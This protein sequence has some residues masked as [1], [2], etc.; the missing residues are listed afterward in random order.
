MIHIII[1]NYNGWE[2]SIECI[3]SILK[4]TFKKF[5]ITIVDN[6]S[7]NCSSERLLDY[8]ESISSFVKMQHIVFNE[9]SFKVHFDSNQKSDD[10]IK[11]NKIL[12]IES[13]QNLGFAAGNNAAIDYIFRNDAELPVSN[14]LFFLLNP[15][16]VI[17]PQILSIISEI[18]LDEFI[19]SMEVRNYYNPS[20]LLSSG[21]LKLN[22]P[23]SCLK[24]TKTLDEIDY[25]YGGALITTTKT[26]KKI[27]LFSTE[28]F[29]Y[30]EETDYC[31]KAK[32]ADVPLL[33][34]KDAYVLDKVGQSTGRGKLAHYYF[35]RN[36]F[37][38]YKK[39][40][41]HYLPTLF[42][43]NLIR[44]AKKTVTGK[45]SAASGIVLG[46]K[47]FLQRKDGYKSFN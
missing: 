24:S 11:F 15:D 10:E 4:S 41:P 21:G 8:F 7:P 16:T 35:I 46:F 26:I 19:A 45:F 42:L 44:L 5:Q 18:K 27:G 38:F 22:K 47:D 30:W 14:K 43:Y 36:S 20:Q 13:K 28:Y 17:D 37:V 32:L 3:N 39:Y 40:Y 6:G 12:F 25:V 1:I 29:L 9:G 2:D 31:K 33:L 34:I 23:F